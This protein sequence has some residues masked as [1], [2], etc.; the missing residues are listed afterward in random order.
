MKKLFFAVGVIAMA[1]TA[2]ACASQPKESKELKAI[3]AEIKEVAQM[4]SKLNREEYAKRANKRSYALGAN[5]G[6][7]VNF[8][9]SDLELNTAELQDAIIDFYLNGDVE[10]PELQENAMKF[11]TFIYTKVY[12]YMQA[13]RTREAMEKGNMTEDMPE[14]P[15]IYDEEYTKEFI[16]KTLGSQM[17]A[18]LINVDGISMGWLFKGF[19]DGYNIEKNENESMDVTINAGLLISVEE[20][21]TELMNLQ[22]EMMEKQMAERQKKLEEA[23]AASAEWLAEIE[24][25]E[26][27]QKTES[28]LLYRIDREGSAVHATAD[29]DTV[30]VNYEGKT[31][32]GNIFD[33]SYERGESI[34]F[35]LNRVIK[36]WTEGM[37]LIGEGGQITLWIPA[38]LAYGERGAGADIG[39]NEALEFK[40]ELIKVTAAK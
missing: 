37:K 12:P 17:G 5:M 1:L 16:T 8:Q 26:G 25:M 9:F 15:A 14:L 4:E 28:G 7:T 23:S 24:K 32:D 30:E 33:S 34:S 3:K 10:S 2:F 6:L 35:A 20:L 19:A 36:G 27:V 22:R 31:R 39:P 38:E 13:K 29:N 11:Q 40:V 18:S 21:Q